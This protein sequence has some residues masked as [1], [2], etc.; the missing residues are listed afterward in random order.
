MISL[1]TVLVSEV[2]TR[3]WRTRGV[4]TMRFFASQRSPG[5]ATGRPASRDPQP[6]EPRKT[7]KKPKHFLSW[8]PSGLRCHLSFWRFFSCFTAIFGPILKGKMANFGAKNAVKQ[9]KNAK[10]TNGTYFTRVHGATPNSL[11]N[12]ENTEKAPECSR[13]CVS[14]GFFSNLLVFCKGFGVVP[15][16]DIF[17]F[18]LEEFWS[19]GILDPCSWSGVSQSA[20]TLPLNQEGNTILRD[21]S[22]CIFGPCLS[23]TLGIST[24]FKTWY[25]WASLQ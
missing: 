24:C 5:L 6:P 12:S 1:Q 7:S 16:K 11:K 18:L 10:R 19:S 25:L 23:L 15:R 21:A 13:K 3:G 9:G 8:S 22:C 14:S 20:A 2:P 17:V 4:G